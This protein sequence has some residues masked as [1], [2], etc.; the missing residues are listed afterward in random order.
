MFLLFLCLVTSKKKIFSFFLAHFRVVAGTRFYSTFYTPRSRDIKF[1]LALLTSGVSSY[2]EIIGY[3]DK[4]TILL[5]GGGMQCRY[6]EDREI[7]LYG[8]HHFSSI[9]NSEKRSQGAQDVVKVIKTERLRP[10]KAPQI[11]FKT[12]CR[13][14]AN[15]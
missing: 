4:N 15:P 12:L 2:S 10:T 14:E 13:W 7:R 5:C 11:M 3:G 1:W 8:K 6:K 9:S